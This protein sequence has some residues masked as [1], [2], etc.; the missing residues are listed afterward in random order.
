M[1]IETRFKSAA[2]T[3]ELIWHEADDSLLCETFETEL[4][5]RGQ[6]T[7]VAAVLHAQQWRHSARRPSIRTLGESAD[8]GPNQRHI[9]RQRPTIQAT[10]RPAAPHERTCLLICI[11]VDPRI[12]LRIDCARHRQH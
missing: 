3:Y 7:T 12:V 6:L 11:C 4:D 5:F 8:A 1:K 9:K 10:G 2:Q